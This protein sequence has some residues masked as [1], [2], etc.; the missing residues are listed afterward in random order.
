MMDVEMHTRASEQ[1]IE[2]PPL[3]LPPEPTRVCQ[4]GG[5][6]QARQDKCAHQSRR[7]AAPE[8]RPAS[9]LDIRF[10]SPIHL[11][12]RLVLI[13]HA[14]T[15]LILRSSPCA[16]SSPHVPAHSDPLFSLTISC[17]TGDAT[18]ALKDGV[19]P[20]PS[21][22]AGAAP[23]TAGVQWHLNAC[24]A[25]PHRQRGRHAPERGAG[26]GVPSQACSV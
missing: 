25:L 13:A 16:C 18:T 2:S 11:H 5:R 3:C 7:L 10:R 12:I 23:H 14:P 15:R 26:E 17:T 1:C 4:Y 21:D 22:R 20:S 24:Y 9:S 6:K 8:R 19:P